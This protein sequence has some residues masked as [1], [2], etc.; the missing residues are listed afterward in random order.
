M[1]GSDM[2]DEED[3]L[4]LA[5]LTPVYLIMVELIVRTSARR[6]NRGKESLA[7]PD[8]VLSLTSEEVDSD[9]P[10]YN[11]VF[12]AVR[13]E[14][15]LY[16]QAFAALDAK[17]GI[18]LGFSGAIVALAPTRLRS[19]LSV[20]GV[21]L[22]MVAAGVALYAS[23]PRMVGM[24]RPSRIWEELI[25]DARPGAKLLFL[26]QELRTTSD[27]RDRLEVKSKLIRWAMAILFLAIIFLGVSAFQD[28]RN[29]AS[30]P[31][32]GGDCHQCVTTTTAATGRATTW[33][34]ATAT[35]PTKTAFRAKASPTHPRWRDDL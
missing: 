7:P 28:F 18:L 1:S 16:M 24:M 23:W 10:G 31:S 27:L 8:P 2:A 34:D 3:Y 9:Y 4:L 22:A 12:N 13:T 15:T 25:G 11:L 21:F 19:F 33:R 30:Q 6:R 14:R 17:S 32:Q 5:I 29:P 26:G 35:A 20:V